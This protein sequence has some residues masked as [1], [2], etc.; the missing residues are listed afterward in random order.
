LLLAICELA[1]GDLRAALRN[2]A[3]N[4][5][6]GTSWLARCLGGNTQYADI[7]KMSGRF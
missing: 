1:V 4:K 7:Y 3:L 5:P 6:G 2:C